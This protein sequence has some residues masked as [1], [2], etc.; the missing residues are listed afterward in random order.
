MRVEWYGQSAFHLSGA[1]EHGRDRPVRRH[2]GD[3]GEPRDAVRLPADRGRAGATCCSSRT[4][5][6]TTTASRRS[7]ASPRSCARRRARLE[8]PLGEVMAVASEHDEQAGTHAGPTRSSCSSSTGARVPLRRLRPE[9]AARGAGGGDRRGR[10]A[11]PARSAAVPRSAPSRPARS[12]SVCA[13]RWVVPMHYRT[14][15]IGFLETAEEF[16]E[17]CDHVERLDAPSFRDRRLAAADGP[18]VVVPAAP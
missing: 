8:S 18:L 13:P 1:R 15:R 6:P 7:P 17:R 11:D 9:R 5:T 10:P 4:S 2:V 12:S 16:L 14:P 3:G